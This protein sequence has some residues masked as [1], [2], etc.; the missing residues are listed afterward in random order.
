MR[1]QHKA[2][3]AKSRDIGWSHCVA[4]DYR[5]QTIRHHDA[6]GG[7]VRIDVCSCGATRET[8]INMFAKNYGEWS[9]KQSYYKVVAETGSC[10]ADNGMNAARW[11]ER[12]DC[13]HQ[14]RTVEVAEK[15]KVK[16]TARDKKG[17]C[18]ALWYHARI[19][20]QDGYHA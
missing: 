5:S 9:E 4:P 19:H 2:I 7:I 10:S 3:K 13:G 20:D 16:L 15:C 14:H 6:H 8:E 1:H 12:A 11:E 18:S 17:N